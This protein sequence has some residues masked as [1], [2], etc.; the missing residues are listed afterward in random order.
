MFF[1][2]I[3]VV[4]VVVVTVVIVVI[5]VVGLL[6]LATFILFLSNVIASFMAYIHPV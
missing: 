3:V 5:V 1:V 2:V 4:I 6:H